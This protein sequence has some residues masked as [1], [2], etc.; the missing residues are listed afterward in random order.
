MFVVSLKASKIKAFCILFVC[1]FAFAAVISLLPDAGAYLNVNKIEG[2]RE[3]SKINVKTKEGRAEYFE[4][5]GYGVDKKEVSEKSEAL[6]ES[7]DAVLSKYNDLQR[8]QGY[9][10]LKY[11]GKSLKSYT[12][13]VTSFPDDTKVEKGDYLATI[14]CYK[15]KVVA[16]DLFCVSTGEAMPLVKAI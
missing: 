10:L 4:A 1:I 14:I 5:L 12:Y 3:L 11:C 2:A 16:A 7:F 13:T 8:A 9:D 6:P 15:N